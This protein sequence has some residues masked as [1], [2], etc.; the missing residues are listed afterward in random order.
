MHVVLGREGESHRWAWTDGLAALGQL[1]LLAP[2]LWPEGDWRDREVMRLVNFIGDYVRQQ[3]RPIAEAETLQY[4]WTTLRFRR[5][6]RAPPR[7]RDP[8]APIGDGLVIQELRAPL[9]ESPPA[10]HDGVALALDLLRLQEDAI[11]RN[12]VAGVAEY[13]HRSRLAIACTRVAPSEP[14]AIRPVIMERSPREGQDSGWVFRCVDPE[15][16]HED[17][18]ELV[19]A[20]LIHLV[21]AFP[22]ALAYLGMPIGTAVLF[23]DAETVVFR[24]G[25]EAGQVDP[26][27]AKESAPGGL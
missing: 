9:L 15:H 12:R 16:D 10:Y 5:L 20:H 24:P 11:R 17:P 13:P 21:R 2:C 19:Q 26:G 14:K 8:D 4:G 6:Y 23:A 3:A 18:G 1:E 25:E 27:P 7:A 22:A